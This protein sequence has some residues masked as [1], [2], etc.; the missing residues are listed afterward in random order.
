M[1]RGNAEPGALGAIILMISKASVM[2]FTVKI[3]LARAPGTREI[4][5]D[6]PMELL[7]RTE[8]LGFFPAHPAILQQ[9]EGAGEAYFGAEWEGDH[10]KLG[11]RVED[12]NW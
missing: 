6:G 12:E 3:V 8:L 5:R 4:D 7:T 11:R 1:T 10:L 9:I 2:T